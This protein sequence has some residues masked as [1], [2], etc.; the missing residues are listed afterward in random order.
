MFKESRIQKWKDLNDTVSK[1][2]V[3]N[4]KDD[5]V[6][7]IV[8]DARM[9][10]DYGYERRAIRKMKRAL[11]ILKQN[12]LLESKHD[13]IMSA[14]SDTSDSEKVRKLDE[15]YNTERSRGHLR[16]ANR[17][18]DKLR[19]N[20]EVASRTGDLSMSLKE[21]DGRG[22]IAIVKNQTDEPVTVRE[23]RIDVPEHGD[24]ILYA[25]LTTIDSRSTERF[26]LSYGTEVGT[27]LIYYMKGAKTYS[28]IVG[29]FDYGE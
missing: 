25:G 9:D 28:L 12:I 10:W 21:V 6:E 19:Y 18:V 5:R 23:I 13:H 26:H 20:S 29:G 14:I 4:L 17:A 27:V 2:W 11:S 1:Y 7:Q 15:K 3:S 24:K 16:A 22:T 8:L